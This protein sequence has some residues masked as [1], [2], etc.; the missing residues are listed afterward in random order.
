MF[1]PNIL[2]EIVL[3]IAQGV[4]C[5]SSKLYRHPKVTVYG[6]TYS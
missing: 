3:F 1:D 5:T 4:P 2:Y 6:E